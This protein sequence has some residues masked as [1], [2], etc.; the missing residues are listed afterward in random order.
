[1]VTMMN[2]HPSAASVDETELPY[3]RDLAHTWW[4][5]T[6]PF[7]PLHRLNRLRSAFIR[8]RLCAAFARDPAKQRPLTGLTALDVGCGG[9][10]LSESLHDMGLTVHGVDVVDRNIQVARLHAAAGGRDI[11]YTTITAEDL[12]AAGTP[13]DVVL[14]MEVVEHVADVGSFM[15]ACNALVAPGGVAFVATI[16]RTWV[17]FVSAIVGAEYILGWLP[18][19]THRYAKLRRPAEIVAL[20]EAGGLTVDATTGVRVNPLTRRF[21]LSPYLGINYMVAASR[22]RP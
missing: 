6:G 8:E 13:Y 9:G 15:E 17:A 7:W 12:A 1:M 20:L 2:S 16:N 21:S 4:D 10:I 3:Y 19:G 11:T 18:R 5:D 22:P 14:N